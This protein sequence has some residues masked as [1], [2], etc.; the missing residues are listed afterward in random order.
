MTQIRPFKGIRY[1]REITGE[2]ATVIT[3]PYDVIGGRE[4]ELY[5]RRSPYN[6]IR[7]EYGRSRPDDRPGDNRYTRAAETIRR[8][9]EEKVLVAEAE[10][11]FYIHRQSFSHNGDNFHRTGLIAA[12]KLEPY[13]NKIVLPHEETMSLPKSDRL[14]LLRSCRANFSPIFGLFPDPDRLLK[15]IAAPVLETE[16]LLE[17]AA[18]DIGQ[19]HLLWAVREIG[20]QSKLAAL[21]DPLPVYIADGH[22]RYETA[23]HYAGECDMERE[24]G[25]GF[26]LA[27]LVSLEDPGLVILPTH[28]LLEEL[29]AEQYELLERILERHFQL[30][31]RGVPED[32]DP[33]AFTAEME[34]RGEE[35]PC[36]GLITPGRAALLTPKKLPDGENLDVDILQQSIMRPL[37][38]GAGAEA[39]E[40]LLTFTHDA[41]EAVQAVIAGDAAGAFLLNPTPMDAVTERSLRGEVMP[42]KSTYFYPKLPSGLVIYHHDLSL[43]SLTP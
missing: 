34:K 26:I 4:Q 1:N 12:L 31:Q 15:K 13:E 10:P 18:D 25:S 16:P 21:L 38:G 7:L 33:Y 30:L 40:Q 29:S 9:L 8:W 28:R 2:P 42:Q 36:L 27:N 37:F 14:E 19:S 24:P 6:I 22:H 3:P 11:A 41:A 35:Y 32:L 43:S 5:Y 20:L 17:I 23:L 39:L